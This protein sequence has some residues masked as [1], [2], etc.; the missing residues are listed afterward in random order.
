MERGKTI[1]RLF[2]TP[3]HEY[4]YDTGT[5]KVLR[6]LPHVFHLLDC[7]LSMDI[8]K[9]VPAFLSKYGEDRFID[10]SKLI[11]GAIE[12]EGVLL[13]TGASRFGLSDHYGTL[14]NWST[15]N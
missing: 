8:D 7:F 11:K 13:S 9:A 12:K 14:K 2:K 5:S 4:F 1:A 6:C 3:S 15:R 10:A